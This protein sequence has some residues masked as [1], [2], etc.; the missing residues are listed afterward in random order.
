LTTKQLKVVG[1]LIQGISYHAIA[2]QLSV[3]LRT[4]ERWATRPDV[5]QL[6]IEAQAKLELELGEEIFSKC[7]S[8]LIKGL[9]KAV[10]RTLEALDHPDARIQ[11]RAAEAI[12]KWTGFYQPQSQQLKQEPQQLPEENLKDYLT[13]LATKNTNGSHS[14][15]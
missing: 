6:V 10:R 11:I 8:G 1:L 12:A 7:K 5:R 3:G 9:P 14:S 13:Y 2:S 15:N 4:V